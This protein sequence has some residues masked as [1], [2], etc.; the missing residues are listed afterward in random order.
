MKTMKTSE[1]T[2]KA[3][4]WVVAKAEGWEGWD[5]DDGECPYFHERNGEQDWLAF[6]DYRPTENWTIAGPIIEREGI[7]LIRCDDTFAK[8]SEG[9]TTLQR[10]PVW[11]ATTGQHSQQVSIDHEGH[12]V[13]YQIDEAEV[14]YGPTPLVAAMRAYAARKPGSVV[15]VPDEL[16]DTTDNALAAQQ[17]AAVDEAMVERIAALLH[18]EA[19]AEPWTVAGVEHPGPDR[20]YYRGLARKVAALAA[21]HREESKWKT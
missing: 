10:I 17:P 3:L 6:R 9:F 21:R 19:T 11:C 15:E 13:M 20:G 18:E 16:P 1:L 5:W 8:D 2:G 14:T 4:D 12:E 7:T